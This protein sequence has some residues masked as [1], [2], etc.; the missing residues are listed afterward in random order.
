MNRSADCAVIFPA[1]KHTINS[2]RREEVEV[3][4]P[5]T[6]LTLPYIKGL[7]EAIRH[8]LTSL[9]VNVVFRPLWTLCQMLV[10]LKD[11]VPVEECK[12]VV[13]SIPCVECS[14]VYIG[15]M[16]RSLKQCVSEHHCA[17]KN[18]NSKHPPWQSMCSRIDMQWTSTSLRCWTI[19]ST[20]PHAACCRAGTSSTNRQS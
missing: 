7:S 18:R 11:P 4:R 6:T 17:L 19:T 1:Q 10:H 5:K 20:P 8:V 15:Q 12:E 13:Y 14:S 9:G 2:R 3:K 16:R